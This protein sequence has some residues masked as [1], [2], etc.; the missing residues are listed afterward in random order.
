MSESRPIAVRGVAFAMLFAISCSGGSGSSCGGAGCGSGC[1][2]GTYEFPANDPNRPDAILQ[3]EVARARITQSFIDFIK[4]M[5]PDLIKAS[6]GTAG[7]GIRI[8]ANDVLHVPIPDTDLFDI[9]VAEARLRNGE[10]LLWLDD[11]DTRLFLTF[12]PPNG[13]RLSMRNMRVGVMLDLKEDVAGTTSSCPVEGALGS[14][15]VRHAAEITIDVLIEP[16]AGPDPDRNIDIDVTVDDIQLNDLEIDIGDY[17]GESEC[18][19]CLLEE[20]FGGNC[21]DP[22]GRCAECHV[23]CGGL[24]NGLASLVNGL[25]GVVRPLLNRVMRPIVQNFVNS[26]VADINGQPAKLETQIALSDLL[27]I[28]ALKQANPFGVF[29][30][31]EVG[32]FPVVD[33]MNERGMEITVTGGAE[34]EL[35]DCIPPLDDFFEPKGPVPVLGGLDDRGRPYHVGFTMAQSMMNQLLYAM[36]RSGSLCIKLTSQDVKE[37]AG[38][39]FTLNASVLSL[40]ASDLSKI[41]TD[42]APVIIQ[43]KPRAAPL[44]DLGSGAVIGQDAMGN[45]VYDWLLKLGVQDLGIAFH[46]LVHDRYVRIFEVLSDISVGLNVTVLPDNKLQIA[47]GELKID[48]FEETF[49]EILP[50]A[51]FAQVLPTLIDLA[52]QALLQRELTFDLDIT[53]TLSNSLGGV[54]LYM[55][56]NEIKRDGP[57]EDYLTVTIT[58][59]DQPGANLMLVAET[60]A[61]LADDAELIDAVDGITRASGHVKLVLGEPLIGTGVDL[62]YQVRVDGGLWQIARSPKN[63][64]TLRI[65]DSRLLVEG[66][67]KLE[68]RARYRDA[69]ETLDPTPAE[70]RVQIDTRAPIVRGE[71]AHD[72][73]LVMVSDAGSK[74]STLALRGRFDGGEWFDVALSPLD[75]HLAEA[76]VPLAGV[77]ATRLELVAIDPLGNESRIEKVSVGVAGLEPAPIEAEG[78]CACSTHSPQSGAPA[79]LVLLLGAL[80][81]R[82]RR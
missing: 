42:T 50:N 2:S 40:L 72:G 54:P 81:L 66:E 82:R 35:A 69:Y 12:E 32:K 56:I 30:A 21:L 43:L 52:L 6:L 39:S 55:R 41:A 49:N 5:L 27:P 17:C 79:A 71:L 60:H 76:R 29:I 74:A 22:G 57:Q 7:N 65:Q 31:P 1:G 14:G 9:G 70:L 67:H 11:L 44:V 68:V 80:L 48:G 34:A 20:P 28:E 16:G 78:G 19:D 58:F 8:D 10:A 13:V 62:E 63:D 23:F 15:P 61:R 45:D 36:H 4:P 33:R 47:V 59:S 38:G 77:T 75:D 37:L 46:V 64:G 51:D 3:R 18:Q 24:T 73:V 25:V 26:A 53:D